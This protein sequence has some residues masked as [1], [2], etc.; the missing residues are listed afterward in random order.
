MLS[1]FFRDEEE[2]NDL[3]QEVFLQLWTK[4]ESLNAERNIEGFLFTLL[5]NKCLNSLKKSIIE[6]KFIQ[7]QIRFE[8]ERLYHI[9]F[10]GQQEFVRMEEQLTGY[11]VKAMD[12]NAGKMP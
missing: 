6:E 11:L 12:S 8:T 5:K 4:K 10:S 9:S 3:V 1:T 2:V 7:Q